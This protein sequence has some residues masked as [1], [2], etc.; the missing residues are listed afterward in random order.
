MNSYH[1]V[2]IG[3]NNYVYRMH[4][5][6]FNVQLHCTRTAGW[7]LWDVTDNNGN[8]KRLGGEYE[9]LPFEIRLHDQILCNNR[10]ITPVENADY[11]LSENQEF[12]LGRIQCQTMWSS[13]D[14][15]LTVVLPD[16]NAQSCNSILESLVKYIRRFGGVAWAGY[17]WQVFSVL[18]TASPERIGFVLK[19]S[20]PQTDS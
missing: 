11:K 4:D 2:E 7:E 13:W 14:S 8:G 19:L 10:F 5:V 12:L 20:N 3:C 15:I 6:P 16:A 9:N 17:F 1:D 18:P